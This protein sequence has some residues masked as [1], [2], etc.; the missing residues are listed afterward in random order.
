[1]AMGETVDARPASDV[2]LQFLAERMKSRSKRSCRSLALPTRDCKKRCRLAGQI[3]TATCLASHVAPDYVR[4]NALALRQL[5]TGVQ[6]LSTRRPLCEDDIGELLSVRGAD[7]H[8]RHREFRSNDGPRIE[9]AF[10]SRVAELIPI[11]LS[12]GI[13]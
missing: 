2:P 13:A 7:H 4:A 1:M 5:A 11:H 10:A 3:A 6:A 9:I 8:G 12:G